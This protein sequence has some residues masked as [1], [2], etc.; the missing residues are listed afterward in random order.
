MS[1]RLTSSATIRHHLRTLGSRIPHQ[2]TTIALLLPVVVFLTL[3]IVNERNSARIRSELEYERV[4]WPQYFGFPGWYGKPRGRDDLTADQAQEVR[5]EG[6]LPWNPLRGAQEDI[7]RPV[8][9]LGVIRECY[10]HF[11]SSSVLCSYCHPAS[12]PLL[13]EQAVFLHHLASAGKN[14]GQ[15]NVTLRESKELGSEKSECWDWVWTFEDCR[16]HFRGS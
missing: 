2:W 5:E 12:N 11:S 10:S 4:V 3:Y 8:R 13:H 15:L 9:V 1:L 14:S 6:S 7:K 16:Q